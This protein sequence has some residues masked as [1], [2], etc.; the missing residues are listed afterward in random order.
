M[1]E[2][3]LL[4]FSFLHWFCSTGLLYQCCSI[5][6][7][8]ESPIFK[9][10]ILL[11]N[12]KWHLTYRGK[13]ESQQETLPWIYNSPVCFRND[14]PSLTLSLLCPTER[15]PG[16]FACFDLTDATASRDAYRPT[17]IGI[18]VSVLWGHFEE[19][20]Y[21]A[22]RSVELRAILAIARTLRWQLCN[23]SQPFAWFSLAFV[24]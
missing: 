5:H 11:D 21:F 24:H 1:W 12:R 18:V 17:C 7:T 23:I 9:P 4:H 6:S 15:I 2:L 22:C 10:S 8:E 13:S 14:L 20:K 19:F 3:A 16:V